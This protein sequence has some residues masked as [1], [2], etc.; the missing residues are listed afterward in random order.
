MVACDVNGN[1]A[2]VL[3][4]PLQGGGCGRRRR[5]RAGQ[6]AAGGRRQAGR[7]Q[8]GGEGG[9]QG[10]HGGAEEAVGGV[11]SGGVRKLD[12][13]IRGLT[14]DWDYKVKFAGINQPWTL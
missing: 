2:E 14:I 4:T 13:G 1:V 7:H 5:R 9:R 10:P 3:P 8:G 12:N 6:G 11:S